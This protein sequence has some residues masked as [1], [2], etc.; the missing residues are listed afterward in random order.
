MIRA[1]AVVG[2]AELTAALEAWL[3]RPGQFL[4]PWE[5]DGPL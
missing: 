4:Y 1:A 5:T 3:L 2:E